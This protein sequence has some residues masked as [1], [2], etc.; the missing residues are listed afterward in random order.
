MWCTMPTWR[1]GK[2]SWQRSAPLQ[3]KRNFRTSVR[4]W[5]TV[6]RSNRSHN[7]M[8][9]FVIWQDQ[10]WKRWFPCGLMSCKSKRRLVQLRRQTDQP[11]QFMH[12]ACRASSRRSQSFAKSPI[13]KM[14]SCPKDRIGN[15]INYTASTWNMPI[16]LLHTVNFRRLKGISI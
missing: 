4:H 2:R 13:S 5:V 9:A 14:V 15:L 8:P 6:L 16:S 1:I 10:S 3:T 7:E 11:F 12:V